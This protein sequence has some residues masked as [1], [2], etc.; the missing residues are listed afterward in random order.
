MNLETLATYYTLVKTHTDKSFTVSLGVGIIG[1][2]LIITG[3]TA[4]FVGAQS[5]Q[6]VSYIAAGSGVITEF[7]G[8]VF[9]YLYNRT[10]RQMKEYHDSL[11]VVQDALLSFKLVEEA[12]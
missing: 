10:V 2:L 8:G 5:N 11:L 6:V 3:L 7:I 1:F 12:G 4:G 9:F